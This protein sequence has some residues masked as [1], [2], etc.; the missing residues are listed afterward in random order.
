MAIDLAVPIIAG[1][2]AAIGYLPQ[3]RGRSNGDLAEEPTGSLDSEAGKQVFH[4]LYHLVKEH[5]N[6]T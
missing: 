6:T 5:G 4:I 3:R 2:L 1:L